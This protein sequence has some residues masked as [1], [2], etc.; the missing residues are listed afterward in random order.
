MATDGAKKEQL[1]ADKLLADKATEVAVG[2]MKGAKVGTFDFTALLE[3]IYVADGAAQTLEAGVEEI[4]KAYTDKNI[5][6]ALIGA[7]ETV[8]FIKQVQQAIPTCMAVE[9]SK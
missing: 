1:K 8:S 7:V 5:K 9:Q 6:E 3:C 2:F 4:E